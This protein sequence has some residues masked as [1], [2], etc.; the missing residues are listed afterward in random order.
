[1]ETE[2]R[3]RIYDLVI[4]SDLIWPVSLVN[5]TNPLNGSW[6]S[7]HETARHWYSLS[8]AQTCRKIRAEY[9]PL[10]KRNVAID[11][12]THDVQDYFKTFVVP[13]GSD[14]HAL[15]HIGIE[16]SPYSNAESESINILPIIRIMDSS[17]HLKVEFH[18]ER[19][20]GTDLMITLST[21]NFVNVLLG[22]YQGP[23]FRKY[24]REAI[25]AVQI[26]RG[27]PYTI[28]FRIDPAFEEHWMRRLSTEDVT[29]EDL[30]DIEPAL[31][32]WATS[33][34]LNIVGIAGRLRFYV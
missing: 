14:H 31:N 18:F 26:L 32:F 9:I 4:P 15:G 24:L 33:K 13:P 6:L 16:F 27:E 20:G 29:A 25:T 3:N 12:Y 8:L 21:E 1:M 11:V 19:S 7:A 17:I 5:C 23:R 2:I 10:Y 22:N 34:G 28:W 30:A